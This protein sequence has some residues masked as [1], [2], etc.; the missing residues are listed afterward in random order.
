M[1]PNYEEKQFE[2][3]FQAEMVTRS[4]TLILPVAPGQVLEA[5]VGFDIAA[6]LPGTHPLWALVGETLLSGA[7]SSVWARGR[8]SGSRL[9]KSAVNMFFQHKR[10]HKLTRSNATSYSTFHEPFFRFAIDREANK[11]G[12]SQHGTL[13]GLEAVMTGLG[14]VRYSAPRTRDYDDLENWYLARSL[15]DHCVYVPPSSFG[16]HDRCIFTSSSLAHFNPDGAQGA[17]QNWAELESELLRLTGNSAREVITGLGEALIGIEAM[18]ELPAFNL[19]MG[20]LGNSDQRYVQSVFRI[21]LLAL[22]ASAN[23][24]MAVPR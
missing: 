3:M 1:K 18:G 9:T 16:L 2:T 15:L 19:N 20:A 7:A 17:A 6:S 11:R 22:R 10:S 4:T 5:E 13:V 24:M 8:L 21:Q 23:W 12:F 14:V